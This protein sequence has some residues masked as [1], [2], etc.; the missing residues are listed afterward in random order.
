MSEPAIPAEAEGYEIVMLGLNGRFWVLRG[1]EHLS[2]MLANR[3]GWPQPAAAVM[4]ESHAQLVSVLPEGADIGDMHMVNGWIV[5]RLRGDAQIV[6][7]S[8]ES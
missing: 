2:A 7:L 8:L 4:L 5:E 1:E 6:E 3:S